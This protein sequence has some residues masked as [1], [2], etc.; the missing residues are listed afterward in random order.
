MLC[1][2]VIPGTT[3]VRHILLGLTLL[4]SIYLI[5]INRIFFKNK[6]IYWL[7]SVFLFGLLFWAVVHLVFFSND[8]QSELKQLKGLWVRV[9]IGVT[10]GFALGLALKTASKTR[11]IFF[12]ALFSTSTINLAIY[13]F[14]SYIQG[15]WILP[16]AFVTVYYFNKIE[17]AYFG[18]IAIA[19]ASS[20][21]LHCLKFDFDKINLS[22]LFFWFVGI[23]IALASSLVSS[24]KNGIAIG[25]FLSMMLMIGILY[26]LAFSRISRYKVSLVAIFF[27]ISIA[28]FW[29]AH[30]IFASQGWDTLFQDISIAVQVE[31]FP[32]WKS[33]TGLQYPTNDSGNVVALNTYE[34]F[35]WGTVGATLITKYPMGYGLINNSFKKTLD[36]DGVVHNVPGQV[37]SGWIDFGLAYGFPGLLLL[38]L[39]LAFVLILGIFSEDR[40]CRISGWISLM[41]IPFCIIAEMSY[42]QYFESLLF[43]VALSC[44]FLILKNY[45]KSS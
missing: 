3:A 19:V 20:Q 42:K 33:N 18:G 41:M 1:F 36:L 17:A 4:P 13:L 11:Y 40:Y 34:R 37:H 9:L 5:L 15:V 22:R 29:N 12:I 31:K 38:F 7:P 26:Q 25:I 30:K 10:I 6:F 43:F 21:I 14:Q 24:S 16:N 32:Q 44:S 28:S 45:Q 39:C 27:C 2:W 35:A 23:F 8:F